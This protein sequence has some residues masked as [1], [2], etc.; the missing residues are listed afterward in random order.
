MPEVLQWPN[1]E[2]EVRFWLVA[3]LD[4]GAA[5][6]LTETSTTVPD[7]YVTLER[8][9]GRSDGPLD[10]LVTV[11]VA[12]HAATRGDMWDLAR[13]VEFAMAALATNGTPGM[14]VDE[15]EETF[16]F[17]SDPPPDQSRRRAIATYTLTVRPR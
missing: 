16:S 13:D 14:Y 5:G 12:V 9:G 8:V 11:E 2:R 17:A 3:H 6:V 1:V 10:K 15:V 7:R 4:V